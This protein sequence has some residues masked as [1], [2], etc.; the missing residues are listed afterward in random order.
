MK[1]IYTSCFSIEDF[2]KAIDCTC[3]QNHIA[4][5]YITRNN[6]AKFNNIAEDMF[7]TTSKENIESSVMVTGGEIA[8]TIDYVT[9]NVQPLHILH[10]NPMKILTKLQAS[11][12]FSGI[13]FI[14]S[15]AILDETI[16]NRKPPISISQVLSSDRKP[17]RK[18]SQADMNT[19][20][21]CIG[22][23]EHYIKQPEHRLKKELICSTLY[24]LILES[25][26]IIFNNE[27]EDKTA[28]NSTKKIYIQKFIKLLIQF[29][30]REHNPA[31]YADKL[32]ISVQYLSLILKEISGKTANAWIAGYLITR[33]K[34]L[35]RSPENTIQQITETLNFSD[36]SS[37]GKFFKKHTGVSPKK[38]KEEH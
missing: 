32:C 26:K 21:T 10:I 25:A 13:V 30:D 7:L 2:A 23:I 35:L 34:V 12:D 37:F 33:A 9:Y 16:L 24:I 6:L 1:D 5:A 19:F 27:P 15:R 11:S 29:A 18:L 20:K 8:A 28:E 17:F 31:F 38:Y 22:H 4:I 3:Y 14:N 36:Q